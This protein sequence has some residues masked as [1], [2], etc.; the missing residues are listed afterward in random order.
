M[1]CSQRQA[2]VSKHVNA[3]L[4]W[5]CDV[6]SNHTLQVVGLYTFAMWWL[7]IIMSSCIFHTFGFMSVIESLLAVWACVIDIMALAFTSTTTASLSYSSG[8]RTLLIVLT[9]SLFVRCPS[10]RP[11]AAVLPPLIASVSRVWDD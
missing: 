6:D 7:D 10:L 3:V 2:L 11:F 4:L 1:L 5:L 8:Q 9:I